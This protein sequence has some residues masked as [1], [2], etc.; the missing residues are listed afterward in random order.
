MTVLGREST[1]IEVEARLAPEEAQEPVGG[2]KRFKRWLSWSHAWAYRIVLE[3]RQS[4]AAKLLDL[5]QAGELTLLDDDAMVGGWPADIA[6][7]VDIVLQVRDAGLLCCVAVDPGRLGEL[8]DALDAVGITQDNTEQGYNYVT[9]ARQ[10]LALMN[11][12]VTAERKLANGT[13]LHAE[14]GLMDW[15]VANLKVERLPTGFRFTKQNDGDAKIDP[16]MAL[17]DAVTV[18]STNPEAR[19]SVYEE[20][21]FLVL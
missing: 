10:G 18:M 14:Q 5:E 16:A 1:E 9:G 19:R 8:I 12:G 11:A 4:I 3:R 20:R 15:C 13:L 7:V 6:Q 21:G 17:F 2:K